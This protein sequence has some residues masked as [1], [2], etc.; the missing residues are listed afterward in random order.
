MESY[1]ELKRIFIRFVNI[2]Q[3]ELM[4]KNEYKVTIKAVSDDKL[5]FVFL[6]DTIDMTFG[7]VSNA[8]GEVFGKMNFELNRERLDSVTTKENILT[9]FFDEN[10]RIMDSIEAPKIDVNFEYKMVVLFILTEVI[11][12][13]LNLKKT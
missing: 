9:L 5:T 12:R 2:V 1:A 11:D 10:L 7:Y 8:R 6:D 13:Y 4:K 3:E